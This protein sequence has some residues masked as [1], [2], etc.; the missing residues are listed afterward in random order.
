ME[1]NPHVNSQRMDRLWDS[2]TMEYYSTIKWNELYRA[3]HCS[4]DQVSSRT[5][6]CTWFTSRG[7]KGG[8]ADMCTDSLMPLP[9][10]FLRWV[11]KNSQG[12]SGQILSKTQFS[13]RDP[14]NLHPVPAA[15]LFPC[16]ARLVLASQF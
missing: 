7:P 10:D 9:I 6:Q 2:H 12:S 4:P 13:L 14:G 5:C 8:K 16:L 3:A 11:P 15:L 1:N